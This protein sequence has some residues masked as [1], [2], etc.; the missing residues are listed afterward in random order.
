M[1][2]GYFKID[3]FKKIQNPSIIIIITKL[4]SH[5]IILSSLLSS[6]ASRLELKYKRTACWSAFFFTLVHPQFI[7]RWKCDFLAICWEPF[8]LHVTSTS[9]WRNVK[10]RLFEWF[11]AS[12]AKQRYYLFQL[13]LSAN[14]DWRKSVNKLFVSSRW[15]CHFKLWPEIHVHYQPCWYPTI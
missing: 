12:R 11:S 7:V 9:P 13:L 10:P 15:P 4:K 3:D 8:W 5:I 1:A 2:S 14:K 6:M